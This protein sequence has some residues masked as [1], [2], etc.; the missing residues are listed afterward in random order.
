MER[1]RDCLPQPQALMSSV[2]A[3]CGGASM[4]GGSMAGAPNSV[5][6]EGGEESCKRAGQ[7]VRAMGE[8]D[9]QENR[10]AQAEREGAQGRQGSPTRV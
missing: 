3:T 5:P 8:R 9:T 10:R 7:S 2:E 1:V 6:C 4:A